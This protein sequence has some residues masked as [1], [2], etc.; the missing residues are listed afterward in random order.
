MGESMNK[1]QEQRGRYCLNKVAEMLNIVAAMP[2][3][4]MPEHVVN[5]VKQAA[6][7]ALDYLAELAMM[8]DEDD[9]VPSTMTDEEAVEYCAKFVGGGEA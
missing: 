5:A 9:G 4:D 8:L 7:V 2:G 1:M 6:D 3:G